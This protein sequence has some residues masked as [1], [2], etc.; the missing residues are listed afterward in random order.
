MFVAAAL[1]EA[2]RSAEVTGLELRQVLSSR[3]HQP[4][5][6]WQII[7]EFTMPKMS[8]ATKGVVQGD[9]PAC[10]LCRRDGHYNTM[11][12]PEEIA[13]ASREVDGGSLPD[14][15]QSWERF[16]KSHIR[17]EDFKDSRLADPLILVR[18]KVFDIFRK[19]KVKH[20]CFDPVRIE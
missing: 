4:L 1:A 3:E 20:A 15:V 12:E 17:S 2:L 6:W 7:P 16:G 9:P 14:V 5:P 19:L 18:P 8:P 10:T 11:K 13:Y